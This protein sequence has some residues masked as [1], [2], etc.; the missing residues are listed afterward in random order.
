MKKI[1]TFHHPVNVAEL[2]PGFWVGERMI[3]RVEQGW[4]FAS[5][6]E[7]EVFLGI[8]PHVMNDLNK[9]RIG[10]GVTLWEEGDTFMLDGKKRLVLVER[11]PGIYRLETLNQRSM[12]M[13]QEEFLELI[14]GG[15]L[16]PLPPKTIR[17]GHTTD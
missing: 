6:E 15:R 12:I 10:H 3:T 5:N 11:L 17:L 2:I 14:S 9:K 4:V 7:E 8:I 16:E 1:L 13:N